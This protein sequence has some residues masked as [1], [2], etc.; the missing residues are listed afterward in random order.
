MPKESKKSITCEIGDIHHN[1]ILVKSFDDVCQGN[2]PSYTLVPLPF[3][4]FKFL[5]TR[6]QRFEMIYS[7]ETF[8]LTFE[9]KQIPVEY[10][11]EII[12]VNVCCMNHFR[13]RKL[14]IEDSKTDR[15]VVIDVE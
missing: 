12:F 9:I 5:R 11:D 6:N 7:S 1:N 13:N 10:P 2:E 4:E 8:V 15:V 3:H 14:R